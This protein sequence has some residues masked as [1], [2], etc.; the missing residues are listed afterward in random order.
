MMLRRPG[1]IVSIAGLLKHVD[2]VGALCVHAGTDGAL[3]QTIRSLA[4]THTR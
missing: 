3:G 1:N 4:L 2:S